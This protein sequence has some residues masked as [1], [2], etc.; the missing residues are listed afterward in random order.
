MDVVAVDGDL[1]AALVRGGEADVVEEPLHHRVQA[2]RADVLDQLVDLGSIV[3]GFLFGRAGIAGASGLTDVEVWFGSA[4]GLLMCG[5]WWL[6]SSIA[7]NFVNALTTSAARFS[8]QE[9]ATDANPVR[10][11][12]AW[13]EG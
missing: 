4:F 12:M 2:A 1:G 9:F 3:F 11:A 5:I 8:W 6:P 10:Q 7:W 13:Q